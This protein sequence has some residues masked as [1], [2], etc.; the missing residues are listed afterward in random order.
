[1]TNHSKMVHTRRKKQKA[2]KQRD[3]TAKRAAKLK[4]K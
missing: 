4:K 2:K 3:N 1:M